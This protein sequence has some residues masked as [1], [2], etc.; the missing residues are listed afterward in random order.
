[1]HVFLD[2]VDF[3]IEVYRW[4]Q[5]LSSSVFASNLRSQERLTERVLA[6][7]GTNSLISGPRFDRPSSLQKA[8]QDHQ[9]SLKKIRRS[10][11]IAMNIAEHLLIMVLYFQ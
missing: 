6:V 9:A 4:L 1:M 10:F 2:D 11:L 3:K 7:A 8:F 5:K